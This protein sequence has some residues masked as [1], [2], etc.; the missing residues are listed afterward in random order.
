[1]DYIY[2]NS[3]RELFAYIT[4]FREAQTDTVA[5]DFEGESNL[6]QYGEKLC[7]IQLYDGKEAVIIDPF[8]ISMKPIRKFLEDRS[9][10]KIM[11]DAAGDRAFLYK[12]YRI[13][14]KSILDLQAAVSLLNYE[15][16][17]LSSVLTETLEVESARSKKRFQRYNWTLRPL[18]SAAIEY[19]IED[20]L[21]LFDL[22]DK[23]LSEIIKSGLLEQFILKNLQVQN[24]PHIYNN[25][26][27]LFQSGRYGGLSNREKRLF[28]SLFDIRDRYAEEINLP[29]NT[30]LPN[31]RLFDLATGKITSGEIAI[32]DRIRGATRNRLINELTRAIKKN[33]HNTP[34]D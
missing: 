16:R 9:I 23:L 2:I 25:K 7:L 30:V 31:D 17:D 1:M 26:P 12:N 29:P 34:R 8:T 28:Q 18:S 10:M 3:N 14:L 5:V 27:K 21:Y 33:L 32:A 24:K 19:A 4:G 20:V 15:K 13:D 6:H 11:Y 22:K